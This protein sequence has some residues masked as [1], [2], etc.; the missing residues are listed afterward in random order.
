MVGIHR[1]NYS[2]T[3]YSHNLYDTRIVVTATIPTE[4]TTVTEVTEATV[5][6]TTTTIQ[7]AEIK[8]LSTIKIGFR[9]SF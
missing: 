7:N 8:N 3:R 4:V 9:Y 2:A 1:N 6:E 5:Q